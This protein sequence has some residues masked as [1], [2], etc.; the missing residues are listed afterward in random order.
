MRRSKQDKWKRTQLRIPQDQYDRVLKYG[1]EN[2]L[3]LNSAILDLL[4][5]AMLQTT[6]NIYPLSD[7]IIDKIADKVVERLN[8]K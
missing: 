5:K 3:S 2:S 4:D 6:D 8:Q 7:K 1:D